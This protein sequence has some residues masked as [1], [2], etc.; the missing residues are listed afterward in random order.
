[1]VAA[2]NSGYDNF[3]RYRRTGV[4]TEYFL[5]ENRQKI[6]RDAGLPAAGIA[7]WHVDELGDRDNQSLTPNSSHQNYELTLVQA[8]NLWHFETTTNNYGDA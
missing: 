6:G 3:Y 4:S 7:V 8:D 2:P 5:L 1:M